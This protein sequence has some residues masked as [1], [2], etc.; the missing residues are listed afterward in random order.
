[1]RTVGR[2][3]VAVLLCSA[4]ASADP[5]PEMLGDNP[6]PA[7]D[8]NLSAP[9][10]AGPLAPVTARDWLAALAPSFSWGE[11]E[12]LA[13]AKL[14]T[15]GRDFASL[16]LST[17]GGT[18]AATL[19]VYRHRGN[20]LIAF[21]ET[22]TC[23]CGSCIARIHFFRVENG[24]L[25]DVTDRVWPR[26]PFVTK[27]GLAR[28]KIAYEL[29]AQG[30]KVLIRNLVTGRVE[31]RVQYNRESGRFDALWRRKGAAPPHGSA[32]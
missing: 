4:V 31:Y 17:S 15:R 25:V 30:P 23:C 1:M 24:E 16:A 13:R 11:S 21:S 27:E 6:P 2:V 10:L 9:P 14:T 7:V 22:G 29:A 28:D 5:H 32:R 19:R 3:I 20:A 12:S 8:P 18:H 26:F